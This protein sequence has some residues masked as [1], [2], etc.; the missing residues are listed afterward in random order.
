[1]FFV[2]LALMNLLRNVRRTLLSLGAIVAGV[3]VII[4]GKGFIGG[5][6]ENAIRA[7]VDALSGHVLIEP[8]GYP[9]EGLSHPVDDV[10]VLPPDAA[11]FLDQNAESWTE[12]TL[13]VPTAVHKTDSLR[14][15]AIA[16][17]P[18]R[19][20]EV[21]AEDKW[22]VTGKI[23][24]TQEDG[25]LVSKGVA[26]LLQ[27]AP[28]DSIVL[29]A[30]TPA[31]A[32]N[33]LEAKVAGIVSIGSPLV[34]QLGMFVPLPLADDLL[35]LDGRASHVLIRLV[36]RD[37]SEEFAAELRK[38]LGAGVEVKTWQDATR[39]ILGLQKIRATALNLLVIAL[40]GMSFLGIFNTVLMAAYERIREIGTLQALGMT[41]MGVIRLFVVE[42][43]LMGVA[44]SV[45]GAA[46]GGL[47][48]W[49]FSRAGIDLS[50]FLDHASK[51]GNLPIAAMLYLRFSPFVV[52]YSMIFG[53]GTAVVAS[54]PPAW[55]AST[56][57][58]AEAV[59]A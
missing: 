59:R 4:I 47:L 7:E 48:V 14:V 57:V 32:I 44:G 21:F 31:G 33:A 16:F 27:V 50:T 55:I 22:K 39:G 15:R 30:R 53:W 10:F 29:Q 20:G 56:L 41:R 9:T 54:V 49:H 58:P 11:S 38:H 6:E 25:V 3:A 43:T 34:D 5:F 2:R 24:A 42:G 17:D 40:M 8:A 23:P 1:M 45:V 12:R 35:R 46:L 13:F 36:D 26:R 28:G 52:A 19:D 18:A 51:A 37:T